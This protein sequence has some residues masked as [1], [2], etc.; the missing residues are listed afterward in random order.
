MNEGPSPSTGGTGVTMHTS[1]IT[2]RPC[3]VKQAVLHR[4]KVLGDPEVRATRIGGGDSGPLLK[5]AVSRPPPPAPPLR[6]APLSSLPIKPD[7][8]GQGPSLPPKERVLWRKGTP[9]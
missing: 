3:T 9:S 1:P 8:M 6:A 7:G 4:S 5:V 2:G